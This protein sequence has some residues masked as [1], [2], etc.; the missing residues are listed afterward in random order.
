[1][2]R[3]AGNL[4]IKMQDFISKDFVQSP[5]FP[6]VSI[7]CVKGPLDLYMEKPF[8]H[9]YLVS[10]K[11]WVLK[12]L[13]NKELSGWHLPKEP[14]SLDVNGLR[15][16]EILLKAFALC[17]ELTPFQGAGLGLWS[18]CEARGER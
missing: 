16:T 3:N 18:P 6:T 11:V 7:T 12:G 14:R 5:F 15:A 1:M 4:L 17:M 13:R 9:L 2:Q 10:C 8:I